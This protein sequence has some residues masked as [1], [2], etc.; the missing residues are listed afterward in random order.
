MVSKISFSIYIFGLLFSIPRIDFASVN[1]NDSIVTHNEKKVK[2]AGYPAGGYS[3]ETSLEFGALGVV[4]INPSPSDAGSVARPTTITPYFQFT[5]KNQFLSAIKSD[6]Y[7]HNMYYFNAN[8]RYFNYPDLY[9]GIG[10][11][12]SGESEK[13]TDKFVKFEGRFSRI[14][15]RHN[16]IGLAMHLEYDKLTSFKPGGLLESGTINGSE[17]GKLFGLGPYYKFDSRNNVLYPTHGLYLETALLFYPHKILND[18]SFSNYFFDARY[19]TTV[20]SK[21]DILA[22]QAWF[23]STGG[24]NVPFYVLPRL[25]GDSRLRGIKHENLYRDRNA[26]YLQMEGRRDLFWRIGG[27]LFAGLGGVNS[28]LS[29]FQFKDLKFVYGIGGRFRPFKNERLN[30]RLD[31][32]KGPGSQY[33][34]YL[35]IGE[36]F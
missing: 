9:F 29:E 23:N 12:V 19:F 16:F 20:F 36:A 27:V 31:I 35:G 30:L 21:K 5:L 15:A 8:L 22:L 24:N 26:Y 25:G 11:D 4:L 10:N 32:G 7:I 17:G 13:Y 34:L 33:A 14:I 1:A 6:A 18:Y 2:I 28:T 3:P